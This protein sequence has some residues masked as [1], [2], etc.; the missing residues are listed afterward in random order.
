VS[1]TAALVPLIYDAS[2]RAVVIYLQAEGGASSRSRSLSMPNLGSADGRRGARL[3][4]GCDE[5]RPR[6]GPNDWPL[7]GAPS[8]A[9][10]G[11]V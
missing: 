9:R 2:K 5:I 10:P 11:A 1:T 7:N 3:N 4:D 8:S 6:V